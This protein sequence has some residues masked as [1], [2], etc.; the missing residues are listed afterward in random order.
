MREAD[1]RPQAIRASQAGRPQRRNLTRDWRA[2][3]ATNVPLDIIAF[4]D[5]FSVWSPSVAFS[6]PLPPKWSAQR[7]KAK[8]R[9]QERSEPPHVTIIRA[10]R[11]WRWGLRDQRFLDREPN[12]A[13]VP[14]EIVEHLR[15]NLAQLVAAWDERYPENPV[16][17][18]K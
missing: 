4:R 17:S 18:E 3:S 10:T 13:E 15:Q 7:W 12:P 5:I 14:D 2:S 11:S 16:S 9:D 6:L 1:S 8:I